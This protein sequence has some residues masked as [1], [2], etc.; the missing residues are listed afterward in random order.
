MSDKDNLDQFTVYDNQNFDF[1]MD[2]IYKDF[3]QELDN[4]R[5][6][7]VFNPE[8]AGKILKNSNIE[9]TLELNVENSYQESR[10]HAFYRLLGL[11]VIGKDG[12]AYSP[13]HDNI[14]EERV[15]NKEAK[16]AIALNPIDGFDKFTL[17]RE[18]YIQ[19]ILKIFSRPSSIDASCLAISSGGAGAQG[20]PSI[21]K[22][23]APFD[24]NDDPFDFNTD[25]QSYQFKLETSAGNQ[26]FLISQFQ[27]ENGNKPQ[28]SSKKSHFIKPLMVNGKIDFF[29]SPSTK[30]VCV[31]FIYNKNNSLISSN[32]YGKRPLIEKIIREKL[33]TSKETS[34]YE[35][36]LN[37][38][39]KNFSTIKDIGLVGKA[40]SA[41]FSLTNKS[42]F[43]NSLK[44][45]QE[46]IK[47]L[48]E[49]TNTIKKTQGKYY[50]LPVPSK[51][52][53]EQGS[54]VKN[55][56]FPNQEG[57]SLFSEADKNVLNMTAQ[58]LFN[59]FSITATEKKIDPNDFALNDFSNSFSQDTTASLGDAS[60]QTLNDL[61]ETRNNY[62][63]EANK[64]LQTVEIIM[65]EFSGLGLCDVFA[66]TG[67][68][69]ILPLEDLLGLIDIDAFNRMGK[70]LNL[71]LSQFTRTKE[72]DAI[73]NLSSV[74]KDFYL[75]MDQIYIDQFNNNAVK[76]D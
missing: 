35:D 38:K 7:T 41:E 64:A 74:V 71:D 24:K 25:N 27:D 14:I 3:I 65:G 66:I 15:L 31:P 45:I 49:A 56:F 44:M 73:K 69:E 53:P 20:A 40:N 75:I 9:N 67:A 54:Q 39:I 50:W 28:I 55:L 21:R 29:V 22:F 30:R 19:S 52:G 34:T 59:K 12:K 37:S 4:I 72:T 46:M 17:Y 57:L 5:S 60:Q 61:V 48:V 42:K 26:M 16:K 70:I 1:D 13:G 33:S 76:A 36:T 62:L 68:L 2:K 51:T 18:N 32:F 47:K 8:T 43:L 10:A 58:S 6:F 11:P 23:V 63:N